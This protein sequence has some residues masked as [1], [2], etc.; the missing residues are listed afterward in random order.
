[1]AQ[2]RKNPETRILPFINEALSLAW[3]GKLTGFYRLIKKHKVSGALSSFLLAKE[4]FANKGSKTQPN[5]TT[6]VSKLCTNE[7]A[8]KLL[9]EF[10]FFRKNKGVKCPAEVNENSKEVIIGKKTLAFIPA[11]MLI[12]ELKRRGYKG[13]LSFTK[14]IKI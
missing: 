7:E 11:T 8:I 12:Q 1:M 3:E 4:I 10:R 5:Y 6:R 9:E 13:T 14:E 2:V